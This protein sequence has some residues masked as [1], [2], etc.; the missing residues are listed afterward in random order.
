MVLNIDAILTIESC[1]VPARLVPSSE[2]NQEERE[3]TFEISEKE[4]MGQGYLSH[5]LEYE[6]E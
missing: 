5:G 2:S 1:R 3:W 4:R 6:E